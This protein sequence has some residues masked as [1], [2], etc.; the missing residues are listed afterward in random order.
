MTGIGMNLTEYTSKELT[1]LQLAVLFRLTNLQERH[2]PDLLGIER[3]QQ[4]EVKIYEAKQIVL[5]KEIEL[6]N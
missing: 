4:W 2:S 5:K 3:L 6:L 1:E